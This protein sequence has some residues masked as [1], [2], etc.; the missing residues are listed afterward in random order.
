MQIYLMFCTNCFASHNY[1]KVKMFVYNRFWLKNLSGISC[2]KTQSL[3]TKFTT[4]E[5]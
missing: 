5:E 2:L 4:A 1:S 3:I